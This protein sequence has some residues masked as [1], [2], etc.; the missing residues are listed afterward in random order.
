[1][2]CLFFI[3]GLAF[4]RCIHTK[5]VQRRTRLF[6]CV[7][8]VFHDLDFDSI[9]FDRSIKLFNCLVAF[10]FPHLC[11]IKHTYHPFPVGEAF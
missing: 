8:R 6:H 11:R 2:V 4:G 7:L 3:A 5:Y 1:M 10:S 9:R